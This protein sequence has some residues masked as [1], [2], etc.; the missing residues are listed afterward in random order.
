VEPLFKWG[1]FERGMHGIV[2]KVEHD[3]KVKLQCSFVP[4]KDPTE[5]LWT[6]QL[7]E[8]KVVD[9]GTFSGS[10]KGKW[11][12]KL[13]LGQAV[14]V[15]PSLESPSTSWGS[16]KR[17]EIGYVRCYVEGADAY[18]CDFPSVDG[19]CGRSCDLEVER[20][21][22]LVRPGRKVRVREGI[23]PT[24][25]WG[26]V[27]RSSVGTVVSCRY[28]G[29]QIVVDF[30]GED[31]TWSGTLADLEVYDKC[32]D[33]ASDE[34]KAK[35]SAETPIT[36]ASSPPLVAAVPITLPSKCEVGSTVTITGLK[37]KSGAKHNGKS[38]RVVAKIEDKYVVELKLHGDDIEAMCVTVKAE[39]LVF[40]QHPT[41]KKGTVVKLCNIEK[42]PELNG[43]FAIICDLDPNT[44][45][46]VISCSDTMLKVLPSKFEV[47]EGVEDLE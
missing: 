46:Y 11:P 14:R 18:I 35:A 20:T 43:A 21:A 2:M 39:N 29:R 30:P 25:G 9:D 45:R 47:I 36:E 32:K 19:W 40:P 42:K 41:H 44:G 26:S 27:S 5:H 8:L 17:D 13:Q 37:T 23:T 15:P 12:G 31:S 38:G 3:G 33:G 24:Y 4:S 10:Y 6:A 16:L 1:N 34:S 7:Q 22:T 28:D